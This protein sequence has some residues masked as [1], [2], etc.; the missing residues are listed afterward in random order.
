MADVFSFEINRLSEEVFVYR[1]TRVTDRIGAEPAGECK[2]SGLLISTCEAT[3]YKSSTEQTVHITV[4]RGWL[5][6][7][8]LSIKRSA[9][10]AKKLKD[11]V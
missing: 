6:L 9:E 7:S 2:Y 5:R 11:R 4:A 10:S 1:A 8:R 3:A